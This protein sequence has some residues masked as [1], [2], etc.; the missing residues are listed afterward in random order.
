[1]NHSLLLS[2]YYFF[3]IC[4]TIPNDL[5]I[6][7]HLAN[8]PRRINLKSYHH[9]EHFFIQMSASKV[10]LPKFLQGQKRIFVNS[11]TNIL[12]STWWKFLKFFPHL[13]KPYYYKILHY[14]CPK[15]FFFENLVLVLEVVV[16]ECFWWKHCQKPLGVK[17]F[18]FSL[19]ALKNF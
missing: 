2:T 16:L 14:M 13:L 18:N 9:F 17:F 12:Q 1:L 10:Q 19:V 5:K 6:F 15:M 11:N 3:S 4:C 7:K 8:L